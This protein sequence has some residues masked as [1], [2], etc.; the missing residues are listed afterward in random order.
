MKNFNYLYDIV[1]P[2]FIKTLS[3]ENLYSL[4]K[5]IREFLIYSLSKTGGHVSANLG[6]IELTIALHY[7]FDFDED[8]LIFDV[9]HQCY[10]HKILTG[11][12]KFFKNLRKFGGLSGFPRRDESIYDVWET[13]HS[14]TS[15]SA[16]MGMAINRDL[17]NRNENI[18]AVIGDGALTGGM[19]LEALNN[20]GYEQR[21]LIIILNDNQMSISPNISAMNPSTQKPFLN[22]HNSLHEISNL[23]NMNLPYHRNIKTL[24]KNI[25]IGYSGPIDGHNM[26]DLINSLENLKSI[27]K[28]HVLHVIT[29]K[30]NGLKIAEDDN[31]GSWHGIGPFD[32]STGLKIK[33]K[34][35][36]HR[37]W[38]S[39]ISET[40]ERL[41]NN[42]D[43]IICITPAMIKGSKLEF[44]A[45]KFPNRIFD[46][47]IAEQHGTTF[48][49]SLALSNLKPILFMYST[50]LQR[51]YDQIIHDI[52]RQNINMILAVDKCGFATG[53]G[54]THHG[55]YDISFLRPIPNVSIIMPKNQ[56]EAQNLL[57]NCL[58]KYSDKGLIAFRYPRG[59][60]KLAHVENF[61]DI[62]FG[63]WTIEKEGTDL[64]IL[65]FGPM[66]DIAFEIS[67]ELSYKNI[68]IKI[69][70]ARFIKPMD[71]ILLHEIFKSNLPIVT[72]EESCK[73]GGFGSGICE[74]AIKHKYK[75]D[76]EIF[77]IED[78]F[79]Q[80]GDLENLRKLSNLDSESI[81]NKIQS[82]IKIKS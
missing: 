19:A 78:S 34:K 4:A 57:Y 69:I 14:S 54:D 6:V 56:T 39:V 74:F 13:G 52:A 25:N 29:K 35:S 28:P 16:C 10:T 23:K 46:V 36:N 32:I 63:S 11:R 49:A 44:F 53:D 71:E 33:N 40:V 68:D 41:A 43:K 73:I 45:K 42:D 79:F 37:S 82:L 62:E 67:K 26:K 77:G 30:G 24:F 3:I 70:N 27:N 50:F 8:K 18:V 51:A 59:Y 20:I 17:K 31:R 9:G 75:N 21:K 5:K 55:I 60:S 38:S 12:A 65:T 81:I 47:G 2:N 64:I 1:N 61:V 22:L 48:S 7:V 72:I 66:V 58:Y 80:H 76:I 15:L